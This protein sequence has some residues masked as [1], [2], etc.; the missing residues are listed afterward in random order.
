MPKITIALVR[1]KG[2]EPFGFLVLVASSVRP[3]A[4]WLRRLRCKP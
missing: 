3:T 2:N 4:R 1:S